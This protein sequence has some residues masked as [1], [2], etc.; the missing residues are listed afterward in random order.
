MSRKRA[1]WRGDHPDSQY[2]QA[3][4]Q[5]SLHAG[6][7]MHQDDRYA[8]SGSF[9]GSRL[10]CKLRDENRNLIWITNDSQGR[11]T[12]SEVFAIRPEFSIISFLP[13]MADRARGNPT[14][15]HGSESLP[16][17]LQIET[18]ACLQCAFATTCFDATNF[19]TAVACSTRG[20]GDA[21]A[22][23]RAC[24][25]ATREQRQQR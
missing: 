4:K 9:E 14:A 5:P 7:R 23:A 17:D 21:R 20:H 19:I 24:G 16:D 2:S 3:L 15:W 10:R 22:R 25:N 8:L 12:R 1:S 18:I 13:L 6:A 11:I